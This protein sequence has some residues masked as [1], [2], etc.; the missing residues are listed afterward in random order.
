MP[1]IRKNRNLVAFLSTFPPRECGI[2]TFTE[3]LSSAFRELFSPS[4]DARIVAMNLDEVSQPNYPRSVISRIN[5]NNI[6][7]YSRVA[8]ELNSR[9]DIK[10]I[11]IQH[12][13]GI[14]GGRWGENLLAFMENIEMPIITTFHS[15]LPNPEIKLKQVVNRIAA[16]SAFTVV[17]TKRSRDILIADYT[18]D[19]KK[20]RIIPH[21]IHPLIFSNSEKSKKI[22]GL[23]DKTILSTFGLLNREKG[24]EYVIEALPD[25]IKKFPNILF[26]IIGATHPIVLK[27]EGE[28]YRNFLEK[29]VY[30]LGLAG[31]VKFYNRYLELQELLGFLKATDIYVSPSLN[32]NQ[33]VSGTMSYALGT[34]RPLVSTSFAQA[35]E[36]ITPNVGVLVEFKKPEEYA[37]AILMLLENPQ[38]RARMSQNAYFMTRNMTWP[39]VALAYMRVFSEAMPL[40]NDQERNLPRIK[41]SHLAK[42]TDQ[43]G[44]IQFAKLTEPD[45]ASGYTADDNARALIASC[46]AYEKYKTP[47]LL[48]LAEKYLSFLKYVSRDDGY[49]DNYVNIDRT[50]NTEAN[51][52]ENM[53]DA[54]ARALWA[55]AFAATSKS[56]P[57]QTRELAQKIFLASIRKNISFTH[58]RSSAFFIKALSLWLSGMTGKT[59]RAKIE[60]MLIRHTEALVASYKNNSDAE[61]QWFEHELTYANAILPDALLSAY[62]IRRKQNF[63]WL[64]IGKSTLEFLISKTFENMMYVPVGQK[65]WYKRGKAK[66]LYDQQPEEPSAMVQALKTMYTATKDN[67]YRKLM[68]RT[69]YWFLGDNTRN[70]IMYDATTGGCYDGLGR[71]QINLNEGAESTLS[72][73]IARLIL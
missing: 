70:Q 31:H 71:R 65:E 36:D 18:I 30:G 68:C 66:T 53:Q 46:L 1:A 55:L 64:E 35:K 54:S 2:A 62:L 59:D 28:R 60:K 43:F 73:L 20:I 51:R 39:N 19:K 47:S 32:P 10:L 23:S 22:L 29:K 61:W 11:N 7:D 44:I 57:L 41:F 6:S 13:F 15:V 56:L 48:R 58:A 45:P 67:R 9:P 52:N 21:G 17:M 38:L 24:I 63:E 72:Y 5:Q 33:A 25:V 37:K 26:L 12:E 49:F 3:D 34:G 14:F 42:L 8:R 27:K 69:F 16:R 40:F 4:V 50:R